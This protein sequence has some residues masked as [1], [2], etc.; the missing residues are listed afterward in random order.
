MR[1]DFNL[2]HGAAEKE[3]SCMMWIKCCTVWKGFED[4]LYSKENA[5][6]DIHVHHGRLWVREGFKAGNLEKET[7][8]RCL[9]SQHRKAALSSGLEEI[10]CKVL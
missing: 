9:K 2:V 1:L 4:K 3:E 7:S 5:L 6:P 8:D 10:I